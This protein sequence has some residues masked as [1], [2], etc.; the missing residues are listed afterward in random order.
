MYIYCFKTLFWGSIIT[1]GYSYLIYPSLMYLLTKNKRENRLEYERSDSLPTVS[2]LLAV[3]NGEHAIREK[4]ERTF[5]TT[6]PLSRIDFWIGSDASS[7]QTNLIIKN[8]QK[9]YAQIN[10]VNF[11]ERTGKPSIINVLQKKAEGEILIITDLHAF[12]E[13]ET[14]FGLVKHFRD[15]QIDI[16]GANLLN[17]KQ[18]NENTAKQ[19]ASYLTHEI[20]LKYRE[21]L[22]WGNVIGIYGACY[23]IRNQS[24][25]QIPENIINDDFYSTMRVLEQKKQAILCLNSLCV[26]NLPS[27]LSTEF[28]R[29]KRIATGNFQNMKQFAHV[30]KQPF[31]ALAFSFFSHKVIRWFSPFLILIAYFSLFIL[32]QIE[33]YK[34]LLY[35]FSFSLIVPT[36]DFLLK[37]LNITISI[38]KYITHFY[39]MNLALLIGFYNFLKGVKTNVWQPTKRN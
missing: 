10:F 17:N 6:Y 22:L 1:V 2:V 5:Q 16:V 19:E 35:I 14:I 29:R 9:E 27:D 18:L 38:F 3:H 4:I 23:A 8:L 37:R 39:I 15:S 20:K 26:E 31:T 30:L 7:D 13:Q 11:L 33:V 24:F 36:F 21:G 12:F 25:E 28:S 32:A 34:Y